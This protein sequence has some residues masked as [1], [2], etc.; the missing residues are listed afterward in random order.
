MLAAHLIAGSDDT[1]GSTLHEGF[2]QPKLNTT[3]PLYKPSVKLCNNFTTQL[4]QN[5]RSQYFHRVGRN[6]G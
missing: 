1:P 4:Y 6:S 2:C 3:D 5:T